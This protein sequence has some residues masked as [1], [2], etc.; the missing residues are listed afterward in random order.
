MRRRLAPS[1]EKDWTEIVWTGSPSSLG[2]TGFFESAECQ[3]S[4][5]G[6]DCR[7]FWFEEPRGYW[8]LSFW[9]GSFLAVAT[10][11]R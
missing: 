3:M 7:P 9:Q 1:V 8:G 11:F 4:S 2:T 5:T 6:E 10:R